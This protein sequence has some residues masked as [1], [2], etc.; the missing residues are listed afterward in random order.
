MKSAI[1]CFLLVTAGLCAQSTAK[2]ES[3][4]MLLANPSSLPNAVAQQVADDILGLAEKDAQPSRQT[5]FEFADQLTK[6]LA[7]HVLRPKQMSQATLQPVMQAIIDVL[8]SSGVPSYR[9]HEAI[10]HLRSGLISLGATSAQA[11][12]AARAL[13]ILGQETRGPEDSPGKFVPLL[14]PK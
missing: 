9:F 8:Q 2:L 1:C 7:G 12:S 3:D 6:A 4:V 10:D 11:Q 5:T 13:L 14:R